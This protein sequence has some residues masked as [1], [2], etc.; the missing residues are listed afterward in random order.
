M[1]PQKML[2]IAMKQCKI[3]FRGFTRMLFGA[4]T[5]GCYAMAGYGFFS[6]PREGGYIAVT[7]FLCA[8][9]TLVM[10]V[11]CMYVMGGGKKKRSNNHD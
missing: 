10:A 7:A 11:S 9:V 2:R 4:A 3:L 6:V 8:S 1:N 5:L